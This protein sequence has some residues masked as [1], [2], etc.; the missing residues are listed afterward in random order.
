MDDLNQELQK[1]VKALTKVLREKEEMEKENEEL[2]KRIKRLSN[3][4][5]VNGI[6]V[7]ELFCLVGCGF[8][9]LW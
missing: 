7:V 6:P 9:S 3:A 8:F 2:R 1:K 4:V 5:Q